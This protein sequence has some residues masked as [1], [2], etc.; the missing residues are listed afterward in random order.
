MDATRWPQDDQPWLTRYRSSMSGKHVP[1]LALE[2]RERELLEAVREAG[3]PAGEL[4]GEAHLLAAED[5]LELATVDEE[6]RTSQGGGLQPALREVGGTMVGL[7]AVA[8]L[9]IWIRSGSSVDIGATAALVAA[10]VAAAFL[11]W[12]IARTLF[13][14]GRPAAA[15][16]VVLSAVVLAAAGIASAVH[17]G[18]GAVAGRDVPVPLLGVALLA[19]GVLTLAAASRLPQPTLRQDWDDDEWLRRFHGGLRTRLVPAATAAGHVHEVR[20]AVVTGTTSAY[21]EFGH[22]L[23]LASQV[24]EA[25]RTARTRRWWV[26]TLVGTGA[27]L[28]IALLVHVND[29][30]G[31]LTVPLVVGLTLGAVMRPLVRWGERPWRHRR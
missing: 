21:E 8:V 20:Q 16:A 13:S 14:A 29:S 9:G 15:G 3:V 6:L 12:V 4:F 28:A 22:P 1:A 18:A 7:G 30:W 25:D 26:S 5:A 2:D 24:A 23:V 17:L 10:S 19:P 27:P 11:G 31:P